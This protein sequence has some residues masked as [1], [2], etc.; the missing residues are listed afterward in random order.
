MPS[1]APCA[2]IAPGL[3]ASWPPGLA[4]AEPAARVHPLLGAVLQG[5]CLSLSM[6]WAH[7][8]SG[9]V[10]RRPWEGTWEETWDARSASPTST[11]PSLDREG[12]VA[13][14]NPKP[15]VKPRILAQR[16]L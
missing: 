8:D 4:S 10:C 3:T 9:P 2:P 7:S 1:T 16:D 5:F 14:D 15:S 11:G 13:L 12:L 6:T